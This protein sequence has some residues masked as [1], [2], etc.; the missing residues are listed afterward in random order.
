LHWAV[1]SS[2]VRF[3]TIFEYIPVIIY[4]GVECVPGSGRRPSNSL[5][6]QMARRE[7][8]PVRDPVRRRRRGGD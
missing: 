3:F 4:L 6:T 5:L 7:E 2:S 1:V 8:G